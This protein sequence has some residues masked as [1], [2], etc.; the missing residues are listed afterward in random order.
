MKARKI[1]QHS[2]Q[3]VFISFILLLIICHTGGADFQAL[4]EEDFF[5]ALQLIRFTKP[6]EAPDFVLPTIEGGE[7]K[8]SNYKG[9]V[10]FLNFWATW[11]PYCRLER[12]SLQAIYDKYKEQG[13]VVL[14]V[15]IDRTSL[16]T[17]KAFI[18]EHNITFPNF[19][20]RASKVATKYEVL[21]VPSTYFIDIHGNVIGGAIGPRP[22]DSKEMYSI[23]EQ[24]LAE[25]N[26]DRTINHP[27]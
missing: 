11:C 1:F 22:W 16:E 8:L 17:V 14:S 21:G 3:I 6:I 24:L 25:A 20:D 7:G 4:A 27:L 18:D 23:V 19:H 5:E 2:F 12:E 10:I 15:S 13:F 9:K 26:Q